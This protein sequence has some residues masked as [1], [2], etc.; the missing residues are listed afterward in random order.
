MRGLIYSYIPATSVL[1][2]YLIACLSPRASR[3]REFEINAIANNLNHH[4]PSS[5]SLQ[6]DPTSCP[7][8]H[9]PHIHLLNCS[10]QTE[11]H[12][13]SHHFNS[14]RFQARA[15]VLTS[16]FSWTCCIYVSGDALVGM[17]QLTSQKRRI[18]WG[19]C[20]AHIQIDWPENCQI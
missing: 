2:I 20:H 9:P 1:P 10:L 18:D 7:S 5:C 14:I 16:P 8:P 4:L 13:L 15:I 19:Y 6:L 12:S 3:I 11:S 17:P